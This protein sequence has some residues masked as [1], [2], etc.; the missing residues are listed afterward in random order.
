MKYAFCLVPAE[1][2]KKGITLGRD[3]ADANRDKWIDFN[4]EPYLAAGYVKGVDHV[5]YKGVA[6]AIQ[7]TYIYLD[8]NM[9]MFLCTE[10]TQGCDVTVVPEE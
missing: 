2:T 7:K 9:I 4:P 5:V 10:S 1:E 3:W 6:Y 8:E